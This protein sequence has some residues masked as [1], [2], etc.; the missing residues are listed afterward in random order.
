MSDPPWVERACAYCGHPVQPY[1]AWSRLWVHQ[2]TRTDV[3]CGRYR[4][5][6]QTETVSTSEPGGLCD[7]CDHIDTDHAQPDGLGCVG[8]RYPGV[9]LSGASIRCGCEAGA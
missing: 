1:S 2:G 4:L 9:K 3:A 5:D 6:C 8:D 7:L